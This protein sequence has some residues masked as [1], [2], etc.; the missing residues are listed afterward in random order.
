VF[1]VGYSVVIYQVANMDDFIALAAVKDFNTEVQVI[2]PLKRNMRI[3][4]Y[5]DII[6][7]RITPPFKS[8]KKEGWQ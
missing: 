7:A 6:F 5:T 1:V 4:N 3:T 8:T 2:G